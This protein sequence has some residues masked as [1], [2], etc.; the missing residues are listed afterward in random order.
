MTFAVGDRVITP[1]TSFDHR[2]VVVGVVV[3]ISPAPGYFR[4]QEQICHVQFENS[5]RGYLRGERL[6]FFGCELELYFNGLD[7]MLELV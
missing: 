2:A 5:G 1:I 3:S 6:L 4:G 7:V